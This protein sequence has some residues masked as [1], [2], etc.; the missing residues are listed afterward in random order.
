MSSMQPNIKER[1]LVI[2]SKLLRMSPFILVITPIVLLVTTIAFAARPEQTWSDIVSKICLSILILF[3][4][5]FLPVTLVDVSRRTFRGLRNLI[6]AARDRLRLTP[7]PHPYTLIACGLLALAFAPMPPGYY[8]FLSIA[9]CLY[10]GFLAFSLWRPQQ[11][12][13]HAVLAIAI[14]ILYNPIWRVILV[15]DSLLVANAITI[16]LFLI[17][18]PLPTSPSDTVS[19]SPDLSRISQVLLSISKYIGCCIITFLVFII[20]VALVISI[21][22][23]LLSAT[24]NSLFDDPTFHSAL[25]N[26][27]SL[28]VQLMKFCGF[29]YAVL[30]FVFVLSRLISG[31]RERFSKTLES[32]SCLPAILI[33]G[34]KEGLYWTFLWSTCF[35]VLMLLNAF[36]H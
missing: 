10:S 17:Y 29:I 15:R 9:I 24:C 6:A 26:H 12:N 34:A 13:Y 36:I 28:F 8:T 16:L 31:L 4:L 30:V 23:C 20:G 14:A 33:T 5:F 35:F 25:K 27:T 19:P 22:T 18:L 21:G 11:I 1:L 2:V 7:S 32:H 3:G